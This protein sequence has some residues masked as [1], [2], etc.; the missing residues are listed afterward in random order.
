M[1]RDQYR[2][3]TI[4]KFDQG[5]IHSA[6]YPASTKPTLTQPGFLYTARGCVS[7]PSGGLMP[8]WNIVEVNDTEDVPNDNWTTGYRPAGG[9]QVLID[10][11]EYGDTTYDETVGNPFP[12]FRTYQEWYN[13]AGTGPGVAYSVHQQFY[14][15][16]ESQSPL[17]S[18]LGLWSLK[19]SVYESGLPGG[20]LCPGRSYFYS[21]G[22]TWYDESS[23]F[24]S[25]SHVVV[26]HT[27]GDNAGRVAFP[28][29]DSAGP[30]SGGLF[31]LTDFVTWD[32]ISPNGSAAA[33]F[34]Q[35][36]LV[37]AY[38]GYTEVDRGAGEGNLQWTPRLRYTNRLKGGYID[39][40][41][42]ANFLSDDLWLGETAE[43]IAWLLSINANTLMVMT[44]ANGAYLIRGDLDYA[45][46][47]KL[48]GVPP[49]MT[50]F[51]LPVS[52]AG[53][54]FFTTKTGAYLLT[55]NGDAQL[56]SG[57]LA[58]NSFNPTSQSSLEFPYMSDYIAP[59]APQGRCAY[60]HPYL[61]APNGWIL[62]TRTGA[63]WQ[64]AQYV[65]NGDAPAYSHYTTTAG[66]LVKA[67]P[68][69]RDETWRTA[70]VTLDPSTPLT[71]IGQVWQA[72]THFIPDVMPPQRNNNIREVEVV[73]SGTGTI[74]IVIFNSNGSFVVQYEVNDSY[75][76]RL[77]DQ[78]RVPSATPA[79]LDQSAGQ[80]GS[81]MLI[82]ATGTS[83]TLPLPNVHEVTLLINDSST[84]A[85]A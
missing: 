85:N 6:N 7:S 78:C 14:A 61:L 83:D 2:K 38:S 43:N 79:G 64:Q 53:G 45:Q 9:K 74:D 51:S 32:E 11:V 13:S 63:W 31:A 82:A 62:D 16:S 59:L 77:R 19:E 37:W 30:L 57:Q 21:A 70:Y 35:E 33:T 3:V 36:R 46:V 75:P 52:T 12:P 23:I 4:D 73:C 49:C 41:V 50:P 58:L 26:S 55:E 20:V 81:W 48:A 54:A 39:S 34:H 22:G 1:A 27:T 17:D 71:G 68:W 56:L 18:N 47:T 44:R 69:Y 42:A 66:G 24:A 10:A 15:P 72:G 65:D 60:Y 40:D 67:Y 80:M 25:P 8:G 5:V 76:I 28:D 29:L 84:I